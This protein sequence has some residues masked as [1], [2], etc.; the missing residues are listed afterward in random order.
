MSDA[1][2]D[3]VK[4]SESLDLPQFWEISVIPFVNSTDPVPDHRLFMKE[5]TLIFQNRGKSES[6]ADLT[7]SNSASGTPQTYTFLKIY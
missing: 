2:F 3:V 4:S 5:M 6:S 7:T 1:E